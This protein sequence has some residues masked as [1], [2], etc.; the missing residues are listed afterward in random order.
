MSQF[1]LA[2][3]ILGESLQGAF[4]GTSNPCQFPWAI[5]LNST[6][7]I[8][9]HLAASSLCAMVSFNA[10]S[11]SP[12]LSATIVSPFFLP[13][14]SVSY[15]LPLSVV[16]FHLPPSLLTSNNSYNFLF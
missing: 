15:I 11:I 12:L 7:A 4:H 2:L 9:S 5:G 8:T 6:H 1:F 16:S 13:P 3:F 14:S 10:T